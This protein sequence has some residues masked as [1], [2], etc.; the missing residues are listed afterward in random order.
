MEFNGQNIT[1]DMMPSYEIGR[2][3]PL[4]QFQFMQDT[5]NNALN[6][7]SMAQPMSVQPMQSVQQSNAWNGVQ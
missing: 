4:R 6:K 1:R 3:Y 5:L 2:D 7:N